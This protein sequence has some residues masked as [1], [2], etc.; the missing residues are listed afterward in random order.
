MAGELAP[1]ERIVRDF[2]FAR[3]W[4]R[5]SRLCRPTSRCEVHNAL[6]PQLERLASDWF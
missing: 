4:S 5:S 1:L 6:A 2:F 3:P